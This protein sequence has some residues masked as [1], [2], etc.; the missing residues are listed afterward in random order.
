MFNSPI[1]DLAITLSFTYF[2]MSLVV[3]ALNEFIYSLFSRRAR[4]LKKSIEEL[5]FDNNSAWKTFAQDKIFGSPHI[6]ALQKSVKKF[7]SYIPAKNFATALLDGMRVKGKLLEMNSIR[8]ELMNTASALPEKLREALLPMFE[9]AQGDLQKFQAEVEA[10]YNN[11][12]DRVA[13]WYK[14]EISYAIFIIAFVVCI[15][16]NVDTINIVNKLW[17]DPAKLKVTTDN[18]IAAANK[19]RYNGN[20]FTNMNIDKGDTSFQGISGSYEIII[21]DTINR[22]DRKI[23]INL[24]NAGKAGKTLAASGV[25]IGWDDENGFKK[26]GLS[27][28]G[29]FFIKL[30]GWLIT[31]IA[32]MLGAPFWFDLMNKFINL[33]GS[34]KKPEEAKPSSSAAV[35]SSSAQ[36]ST[37]VG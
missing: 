22:V 20:E 12:M 5:F 14:R 37:A 4:L 10:F 27:K 13:G 28:V 1:L 3:S 15:A 19:I 7:P 11:A 30:I 17:N 24:D 16:G 32:I 29:E 34:G 18:V 6:Q 23:T 36:P 2:I 33:R 25:P 21:K 9:R 31:A 8:N 26:T 35:S